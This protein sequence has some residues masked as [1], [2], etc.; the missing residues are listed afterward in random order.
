MEERKYYSLTSGQQLLLYSQK[1]CYK[2]QVNNICAR[3]DIKSQIDETLLFQSIFLT[4]MRSPSGNVRLTKQGKEIVQYFSD[5][6]PT[7]IN[8][9][10][11]RN[12]SEAEIEETFN[13]WSSTSFPN[14]CK[15]TQLYRVNLVRMPNDKYTI[16]FC[17]CH[18]IFD[19]Y[20]LM[21]CVK[22]IEQTYFALRN[23][24]PIPKM[25]GSPIAAYE[26]DYA[27]FAS[28]RYKQDHDWWSKVFDSEPHFTSVNG[29]GGKEFIKGKNSGVSLR[30]WQVTAEHMNLRIP[31]ELVEAV[32]ETS[33]SWKISPQS[34]YLLA[35]R[36]YL[37]A[38]NNC[39]DVLFMNTV[40]RR[41]TLVQKRAGGS[42]VNAVPFRSN[43]PASTSFKDAADILYGIQRE[44]YRHANVPCGEIL[45]GILEKEK[46]YVKAGES[47]HSLSVTFQPYFMAEEGGLEY[48][49]KRL[50]NGAATMPL[51]ASIMPYD[52]TGDLWVNYEYLKGYIKPESIEKMHAFMLKFMQAGVENSDKT[53]EELTKVSL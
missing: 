8:I 49:F 26:A 1:F 20:S 45:T 52:N 17:V 37:A 30:L 22:N 24:T 41:A 15:D 53:I 35:I 21:A 39:E 46:K 2:K 40:A 19:A 33:L 50:N 38:V 6:A 42:M 9:V 23:N 51:Y 36:S 10:D 12:A 13:K 29:L 14:G 28:D 16:Y 25:M 18:I 44:T 34:I 5:E 11:L 47:Y 32:Q 3:I 4:M 31:K 27:Y 43:V 48:T 7:N